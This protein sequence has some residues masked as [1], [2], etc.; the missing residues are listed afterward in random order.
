M[1]LELGRHRLLIGVLI[2]VTLGVGGATGYAAATQRPHAT[3]EVFVSSAAAADVRDLSSGSGHA[4]QAAESYAGVATTRLV[5]EPVI[6]ELGLG[7]TVRQLAE[8]VS[9]TVPDGAVMVDITVSDASA[10][11]AARIA[12]AI[13]HRLVAVA[14]TLAP[15]SSSKGPRIELTQVEVARPAP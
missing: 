4:R 2:A 8:Q 7:L 12:D 9:A 11:R 10:T 13:A 5:L 6:R 14:H 3:A 1:H 15:Q